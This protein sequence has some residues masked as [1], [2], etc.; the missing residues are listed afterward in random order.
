MKTSPSWVRYT[1][2]R[3]I[4]IHHSELLKN[5]K[6]QQTQDW[7]DSWLKP[8]Y[9]LVPIL[10]AVVI[11]FFLFLIPLTT[12]TYS[13]DF[14]DFVNAV[15]QRTGN[16]ATISGMSLAVIAF[17]VSNLAIKEPYAYQ[18]LFRKTKLYAVIIYVLSVLGLFVFVSTVHYLYTPGKI[19]EAFTVTAGFEFLTVIFLI[20]FLF[21]KI[22]NFIDPEKIDEM[23]NAELVRAGSV[24]IYEGLI[25]KYSLQEF[26]R[27][28]A[29]QGIKIYNFG[30]YIDSNW[31][32]ASMRIMNGG[33]VAEIEKKQK[34]IV[35]IDLI[36]LAHYLDA[37]KKKGQKYT[38][39]YIGLQ[40]E[41]SGD[42]I[43]VPGISN[44]AGISKALKKF[45]IM[46]SKIEEVIPVSKL[47]DHF[48]E[49]LL[50]Y[51]ETGKEKELIRLLK[52]FT[53]LFEQQ[54]KY[55]SEGSFDLTENFI[56]VLRLGIQAAVKKRNFSCFK[57]LFKFYAGLSFTSLIASNINIFMQV[58]AFYP[59]NYALLKVKGAE[60][61]YQEF[62][63]FT[64]DSTEQLELLLYK[65]GELKKE[66]GDKANELDQFSYNAYYQFGMLLF[67]MVSSKD[68][69]RFKQAI[70]L[71]E[72]RNTHSTYRRHTL[73]GI[74]A[75]LIHLRKHE[76]NSSSETSD[77]LEQIPVRY[78]SATEAME[79]IFE[80]RRGFMVQYMAWLTWRF[81]EYLYSGEFSIS[82]PYEWLT[83][84]FM[85]E[86][87]RD[88]N[89][90]PYY[91]G[92]KMLSSDQI[93]FLVNDLINAKTFFLNNFHEWST[94]L[95][96]PTPEIMATKADQAIRVFQ[97]LNARLQRE[98]LDSIAGTAINVNQ[99]M[100]YREIISR[101][102]KQQ[103]H[104]IN[105]FERSGRKLPSTNNNG[106]SFIG[107][108]VFIGNIKQFFLPNKSESD[109]YLLSTIGQ[110]AGKL[111][112][113][114]FY[115]TILDDPEIFEEGSLVSI[116]ENAIIFLRDSGYHPDC[117]LVPSS[118][119][120]LD[121]SFTHDAR[122]M[123]DRIP[124]AEKPIANSAGKFD[125]IP[126]F[127]TYSDAMDRQIIIAEFAKA[128]V[129]EYESQKGWFDKF[130]NIDVKSITY[131]EARNKAE[132]ESPFMLHP[133]ELD[134]QAK[135]IQNGLNTI[136]GITA[137][138]A[139]SDKDA[140]RVCRLV[141]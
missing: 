20:G 95:K 107:N 2:E 43:F 102:W 54:L 25:R 128:F 38:P 1:V 47:R 71:L 67:Y 141:T 8:S 137:K 88:F 57:E 81:P 44:T 111:A 104:I 124:I 91:N 83:F 10:G 33:E 118:M 75:W 77:L 40:T 116:V 19:Y 100:K 87:I 119:L 97:L 70:G 109:L 30:S 92:P 123:Y 134:I 86:H 13:H 115:E 84:G 7:Y 125:G 17:L 129:M 45:T 68:Y 9:W 18:L 32:K 53:S 133:D 76:K 117:I 27:V 73:F 74:K 113:N 103:A 122:Y 11:Y 42:Y 79:D 89:L 3:R 6:K 120:Y 50:T 69:P 26:E 51:A 15:D 136:T 29:Q 112:D 16:L 56:P 82:N 140:F 31:L 63:P 139:I 55:N 14:K 36:G 22:I 126:I 90:S 80:F 98:E 127:Y 132:A 21:I 23:M 52:G 59:E 5:V 60:A 58:V 41:E 106:L 114:A 66:K 39:L 61:G 110:E 46:D 12:G 108:K 85:V 101:S 135:N 96:T 64:L 28:M 4:E 35:D 138:F 121:E 37:N 49:R 72:H 62:I 99:V 24:I 65:I 48:D 131:E 130:L 105:Q 34:Y 94:I 93:T 78:N